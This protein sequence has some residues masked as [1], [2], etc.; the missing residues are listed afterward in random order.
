MPTCVSR[1][2][3]DLKGVKGNISD[4]ECGVSL[5]ISTLYC[6]DATITLSV[7]RATWGWVAG[8]SGLASVTQ[9]PH[10]AGGCGRNGWQFTY[11]EE[12]HVTEKL[13]HGADYSCVW[14]EKLVIL[15][16]ISEF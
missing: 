14:S 3:A 13:G 2:R 10:R 8:S 12:G 4:D 6:T 15:E 16:M 1:G 5:P 11:P 7:M 9:R